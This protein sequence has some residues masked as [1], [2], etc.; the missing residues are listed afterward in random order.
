M[1]GRMFVIMCDYCGL[2][3]N[4]NCDGLNCQKPSVK[5]I[6]LCGSCEKKHGTCRYCKVVVREHEQTIRMKNEPAG[7]VVCGSAEK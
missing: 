2:K 5:K 3:G 7:T 4:L 6:R 1:F